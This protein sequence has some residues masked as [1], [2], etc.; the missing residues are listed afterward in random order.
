MLL[1]AYAQSCAACHSTKSQVQIIEQISEQI[2]N[3]TPLGGCL[4]D[5]LLPAHWI[6]TSPAVAQTITSRIA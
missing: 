5:V 4:L 1:Y 2:T 6:K 3:A